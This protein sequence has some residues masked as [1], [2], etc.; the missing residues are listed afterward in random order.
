MIENKVRQVESKYQG[1]I[2]EKDQYNQFLMKEVERVLVDSE[3]A[4]ATER[5]ADNPTAGSFALLIDKV[6]RHTRVDKGPDGKFRTTV[7]DED[8]KTPRITTRQGSTDQMTIQEFLA[9][10]K[11]DPEYSRAFD[12]PKSTGSGDV[13]RVQGRSGTVQIDMNLPPEARIAMFRRQQQGT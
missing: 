3:V 4:R 8:G 9:T 1:T 5:R 12:G 10:L 7:L 13:G 2:G 11:G 6:R